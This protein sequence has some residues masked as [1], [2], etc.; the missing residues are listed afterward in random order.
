MAM[1]SRDARRQRHARRLRRQL[2]EIVIEACRLVHDHDEVRSVHIVAQGRPTYAE[3]LRYRRAATEEHAGLTVS[4]QGT[5]SIRPD[6][7]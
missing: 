6:G 1:D 7:S 2:N 5:I 3:L 4:G